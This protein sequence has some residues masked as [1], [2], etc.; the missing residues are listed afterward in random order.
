MPRKDN[1]NNP[2]NIRVQA[3]SLPKKT[4]PKLYLQKLLRFIDNG[5]PLPRSWDVRLHWQNP[6]TRAGRTKDWQEDYFQDAIENSR[7]GFVGIVRGSI[8]RQLRRLQK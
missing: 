7:S 5:E 2:L 8:L 3:V 1:Y 6:E 4:S